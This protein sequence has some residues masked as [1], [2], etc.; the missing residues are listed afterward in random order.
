MAHSNNKITINIL[1]P[2]SIA[3][4]K[5][6]STGLKKKPLSDAI[7]NLYLPLLAYAIL[8]L[9][10]PRFIYQDY[11]CPYFRSPCDAPKT[12]LIFAFVPA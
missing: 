2:I 7:Q 10:L 5:M 1:S 3:W 9:V 6:E 4:N 11:S 12:S 8:S